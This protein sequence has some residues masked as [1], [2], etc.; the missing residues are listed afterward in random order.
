MT[1]NQNWSVIFEY[2]CQKFL[3]H[4]YLPDKPQIFF[5]VSLVADSSWG[6]S[7]S[8]FLKLSTFSFNH[9]HFYFHYCN[10]K[11]VMTQYL[12]FTWPT[13]ASLTRFTL[14]AFIPLCP[15]YL[16]Q[17]HW[18]INT[19]QASISSSSKFLCLFSSKILP[20]PSFMGHIL[21]F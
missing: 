15:S 14:N 2:I 11:E 8:L 13:Q 3:I 6:S 20:S 19:Y 5:I 18:V 1:K 12:F 21:Y 7:H 9:F 4:S 16:Q 10:E 17:E